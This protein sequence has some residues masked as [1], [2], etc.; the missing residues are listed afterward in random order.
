MMVVFVFENCFV[1]KWDFRYFYIVN[2]VVYFDMTVSI[3]VSITAF[4]DIS[5]CNNF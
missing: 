3:C 1:N 4:L 2:R 5:S